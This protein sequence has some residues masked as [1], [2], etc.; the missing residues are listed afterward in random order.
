MLCSLSK[1][2]SG[3]KMELVITI[4]FSWDLDKEDI[5]HIKHHVILNDPVE[6]KS[7][8]NMCFKIDKLCAKESYS[9]RH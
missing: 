7:I 6:G 3:G 4:N 9:Y 1:V 2:H 8:I 5:D